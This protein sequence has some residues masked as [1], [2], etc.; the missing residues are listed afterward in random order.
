V[1][2]SI[3]GD[4]ATLAKKEMIQRLPE[5]ERAKAEELRD[6]VKAKLAQLKARLKKV[7]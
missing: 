5:A 4:L 1:L 3:E 7:E 6:G 2:V